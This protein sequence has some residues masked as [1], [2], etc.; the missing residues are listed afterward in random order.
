MALTNVIAYLTTT[1]LKFCLSCK[2]VNGDMTYL[3]SFDRL[4][5]R[6]ANWSA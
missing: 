1:G 5:N 2:Y 6:N 4:L 3:H